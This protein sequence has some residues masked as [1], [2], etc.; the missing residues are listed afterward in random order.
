MF[1]DVCEHVE[2]FISFMTL[3]FVFYLSGWKPRE[4]LQAWERPGGRAAGRAGGRALLHVVRF[5]KKYLN[6]D[7]E[8][9]HTLRVPWEDVL[10]IFWWL[11]SA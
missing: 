3:N 11:Y 8:I 6:Y 10:R 9:L 2:E 4:V 5:L 7:H 1:I